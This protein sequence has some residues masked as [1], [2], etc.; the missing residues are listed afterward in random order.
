MKERDATQQI[1]TEIKSTVKAMAVG[2]GYD[3]V[4]EKSNVIY[5]SDDLGVRFA[6]D[7]TDDVVKILNKK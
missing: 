3:L 4:V 5:G 1:L 2:K 6:D 7:I